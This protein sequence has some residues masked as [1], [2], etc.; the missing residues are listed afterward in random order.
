MLTNVPIAMCSHKCLFIIYLPL[1][2]LLLLPVLIVNHSMVLIV[3]YAMINTILE[4]NPAFIKAIMHS[5]NSMNEWQGRATKMAS[6]AASESKLLVSR[7]C[8]WEKMVERN[9]GVAP[10]TCTRSKL[11]EL[12]LMEHSHGHWRIKEVIA[13]GYRA[14]MFAPAETAPPKSF[15]GAVT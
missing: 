15:A 2:F 14:N 13:Q 3:A 12:Q 10:F 11:A 9:Q 5:H 7:L 8:S 6:Y 1:Q 4:L